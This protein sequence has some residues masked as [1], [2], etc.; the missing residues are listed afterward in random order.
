[1]TENGVLAARTAASHVATGEWQSFELRMRRRRAERCLLRAEVALEAGFLEDARD[2]LE[3]ARHLAPGVGGLLD[4]EARIAAAAL[5]R[6]S[7]PATHPHLLAIALGVLLAIAAAVI[8]IVMMQSAAPRSAAAAPALSDPAVSRGVPVLAAAVPLAQEP[9]PVRVPADARVERAI[10]LPVAE[11]RASSD[12]APILMSPTSAAL[13]PSIPQVP[14][15]TIVRTAVAANAPEPP[16]PAAAE[17]TTTNTVPLPSATSAP[18]PAPAPIA[19]TGVS[20]DAAVRAVLERYAS[21]YDRLDASAAQAVWPN[22]D[23]GALERAFD[24]LSEQQVSLGTCTIEVSG[25][26]AHASCAGSAR[27]TP[28]VGSGART[29]PR[30]WSFELSRTDAGWRIESAR[31]RPR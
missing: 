21:A 18:E 16:P 4:V 1:M 24:G 5:I 3:E 28:K 9:P 27:W 6:E 25:A 7:P 14:P 15:D 26:S 10:D 19:T 30:A 20:E 8:G 12:P 17:L 22:V 13:A 11:T 23:A 29:E 31:V 2:A